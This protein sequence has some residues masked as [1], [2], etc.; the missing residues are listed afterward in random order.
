VATFIVIVFVGAELELGVGLEVGL[1]FVLIQVV[2]PF[3]TTEGRDPFGP[4]SCENV[5]RR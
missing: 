5:T 4:A 2:A 3:P 1:E